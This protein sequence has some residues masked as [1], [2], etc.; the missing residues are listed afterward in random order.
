MEQRT[1]LVS[2]AGVAGPTLAYWLAQ[3]G[4]RVTLVE[5]ADGQRSSGNPVD[6][7]GPAVDVAERMGVMPRLREAAT[8][9]TGIAFVDASGRRIGRLRTGRP[10]SGEVEVPRADLAAVLY[11]AARDRAEFVFGDSVTAL[12][13]DADGVDVTFASGAAR[14]FD[15][16]IG[17]DGLH[18]AVRSLVFGPE[19]GYA[20]HLGLYVATLSLGRA[21]DDPGT[22][23]MHNT[24]GR[25]VSVHPANGTAMAAFIFR[26]LVIPGLDVHDTAAAREIVRKAYEDG[27]RAGGWELPALL[28]RLAPADD[29]YFDSVSQVRLPAWSRGRVVLAGDAASCLSL[30]GGGSSLA[31]AG[32]ATL[33]QALADAPGDHAAGF[34]AYESRHRARAR[35]AQRGRF[36]AGAL[37]VPGTRAAL[38][39]RDTAVR[40]LGAR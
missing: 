8:S 33:A 2:G 20:R 6:V 35:P 13:Q 16:V 34:R 37:L 14:R 26:S 27:G 38:A 23:V 22:V 17:A 7:R 24:P 36:L 31:I 9:V 15:L 30:F 39:V 29:L 12:A 5:R 3:Y 1:V 4:F 28:D 11:E 21:A 18:S 32:A 25:S 40:L 19:S 10:G